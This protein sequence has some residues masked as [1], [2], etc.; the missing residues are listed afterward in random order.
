MMM[1]GQKIFTGLTCLWFI[2]SLV[3]VLLM[4]EGDCMMSMRKWLVVSFTNMA[5]F[6][7]SLKAGQ[8][9]SHAKENFIFSLRQQSFLPRLLIG[10]IWCILLPFSAVWTVL[11][12]MWFYAAIQ[13]TSGCVT[14]GTQPWLVGFWQLLSYMWV[15]IY[16]FYFGIS[17][18]VECRLRLAENN[19]RL[20]ETP[21]SLTRWGRLLPSS[22]GAE[23]LTMAAEALRVYKGLRPTEIQA[24]PDAEIYEECTFMGNEIHC[25]ICLSDFCEGDKIRPLPGCGHC[26][27]QSCVDLWLLRRADCPLCKGKVS[28]PSK[29]E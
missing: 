14:T 18:V 4:E 27:H 17:I 3:D 12:S 13:S 8:N 15:S 29:V 5:L 25:S 16:I 24:L 9:T 2:H 19:M 21:E 1:S 22:L 26:F 10:L 11:G 23:P 20:I 7:V 28:L 6:R